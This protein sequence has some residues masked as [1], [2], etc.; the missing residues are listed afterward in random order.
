V[1]EARDVRHADAKGVR[2]F[3]VGNRSVSVNL[4]AQK[5]FQGAKGLG[6]SGHSLFLLKALG[7]A[8]QKQQCP[9]RVNRP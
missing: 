7:G 8:A 1:N 9:L 6:F 3:L 4:A 2:G 5:A